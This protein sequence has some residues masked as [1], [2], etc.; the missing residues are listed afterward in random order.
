[1]AKEKI[2]MNP[3]YETKINRAVFFNQEI[4]VYPDRDA[5]YPEN[6][7]KAIR[8]LFGKGVRVREDCTNGYPSFTITGANY[9]L[10]NVSTT[11]ADWT[12]TE[13]KNE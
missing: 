8:F 4:V 6:L 12:Y 9:E 5:D 3:V 13:V 2:F 10:R 11:C 7:V 1:M